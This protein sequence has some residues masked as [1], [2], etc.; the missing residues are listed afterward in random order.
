MVQFEGCNDKFHNGVNE[1]KGVIKDLF[2][3]FLFLLVIYIYE[4]FRE[5]CMVSDSFGPNVSNV[6]IESYY[7]EF[8]FRTISES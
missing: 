6:D 3:R 4:S 1:I 7:S 5:T 8:F 2:V